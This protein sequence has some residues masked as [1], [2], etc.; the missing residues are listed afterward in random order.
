MLFLFFLRLDHVRWPHTLTLTHTHTSAAN[1]S[2]CQYKSWPY[3]H[4][5]Y[6]K[7]PG[8]THEFCGSVLYPIKVVFVNA[9]NVHKPSATFH[10]LARLQKRL[11]LLENINKSEF[12]TQQKQPKNTLKRI[13]K[14]RCC[15]ICILL[16]CCG[17]CMYVSNV[18]TVLLPRTQG[19]YFQLNVTL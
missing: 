12:S 11:Q 4:L 3:H 18:P 13:Y 7:R 1:C 6:V 17:G 19:S 2:A 15:Q 8:A 16:S 10:K 5:T 9:R 14:M